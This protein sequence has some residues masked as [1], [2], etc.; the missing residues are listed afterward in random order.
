MGPDDLG[1]A[2]RPFNHN[3][4][5]GSFSG[6]RGGGSAHGG[7]NFHG[8]NQSYFS[9]ANEQINKE[10]DAELLDVNAGIHGN[11]T[12]ENAKS[13][14]S[15]FLQMNKLQG[16]YKYSPIG[17]DH[18]RSFIAELTIYVKKL[19][20]SITGRETGSTKQ[21]ASKS[22]ALSI[23]RQ[24]FHL[25]VVDAFQGTLKTKDNHMKP[26]P[27]NLSPQLVTAMETALHELHI[28]PVDISRHQPEIALSL[29][30]PK[31]E[32]KAHV[33]PPIGNVPGRV[34]SWSPPV[35]NWN[36]WRASNI[37]EGYL[38]TAT[39]DQLSNDLYQSDREEKQS[40]SESM[41][42]IQ[43]ARSELPVH[44][45]KA[46]IMQAI[47]DNPVVIIK[48]ATG[49]GKTTQIAQYILEDHIAS[50]QGAYCN[51]CV[52]QP[53]RISAT[54]V[55]ERIAQERGEEIGKSVGYSVRF[56]TVSPRPYGSIMMCTVGVLLRRLENGLRGISHIVVDEIHERDVDTDFLLVVLRDMVHTYPELR[57]ILMSATIDTALFVKYFNNCP[58][59]EVPG[60]TFEV[61]Q[62]FLEDCVE[63][64]NFHPPPREAR[65]RGGRGGDDEEADNEPASSSD[66]SDQN[67]NKVQLPPNYRPS[68]QAAM[69]Q[70]TESE[71]SYELIEALLMHT[72]SMDGSVLIFLPGWNI[73][74]G[75]LK[76]LQ[77]TQ[78]FSGPQYRLLPC[79]SQVPREE[80]RKVFEPV[81]PGMKKI[82][83]STRISRFS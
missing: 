69:A 78:E 26:Y 4:G 73:I 49:S 38:A 19:G 60:R 43:M 54:S 18:N 42:R 56:D 10:D 16:D 68:T 76:Y 14:L 1:Q 48:G 2:Y 34:I 15:Q 7:N 50:N 41:A 44:R 37:D 13:K 30:P 3:R 36:C 11:W 66:D 23:V 8:N 62:L 70:M 46:E 79:H 63:L 33:P 59:L 58:L 64:V 5:G 40:Q 28:Q 55:S 9:R 74:F 35:Q 22:C 17:P 57:I 75:L 67:L 29:L 52:T 24:L 71:V 61:K 39:L 47:Y 81:G 20:R 53:R 27:V 12:I 82:I 25:G 51:I 32:Q 21:V 72:R 65:R 80:Q 6:G 31:V 77:N 83:L 45:M